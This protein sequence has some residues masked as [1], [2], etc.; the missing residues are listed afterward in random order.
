MRALAVR[1]ATAALIVAGALPVAAGHIG[2]DRPAVRPMASQQ[3]LGWGKSDSAS[4][5]TAPDASLA[6]PAPASTLNDLGWG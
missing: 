3:D 5:P 6:Q 1:I 2:A 4:A